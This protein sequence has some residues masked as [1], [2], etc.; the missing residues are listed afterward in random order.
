METD[1]EKTELN[2]LNVQLVDKLRSSDNAFSLG[3]SID[4]VACVRYERILKLCLEKDLKIK[5]LD[6]EW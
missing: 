6:S 3:E 2:K 5:I 1:Q 4:G